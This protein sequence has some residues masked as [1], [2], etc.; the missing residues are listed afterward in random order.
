MRC[1]DAF[2]C[3]LKHDAHLNV[4]TYNINVKGYNIYVKS[5]EMDCLRGRGD[6]GTIRA[7][8]AVVRAAV[9]ARAVPP[10]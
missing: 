10:Q 7:L 6:L 9:V 1:G 4:K 5:L 2:E 3:C 8:C